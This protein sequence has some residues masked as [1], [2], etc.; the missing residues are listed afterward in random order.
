M[1][2]STLQK[3]AATTVVWGMFLAVAFMVSKAMFFPP[4]VDHG[5]HIESQS[6]TTDGI[7][8]DWDREQLLRGYQVATE[9]CMSCHSFKYISHRNLKDIG[10]TED[11]AKAMAAALDLGLND[12]MLSIMSPEDAKESYGKEVP[13]LSVMTKARNNG[14]NYVHALLTH[15]VDS[16]TFMTE[17]GKQIIAGDGQY[18]NKV[19]PGYLIAMPSPLSEDLVEYEDGTAATV[20][21]MS[22]DVTAFLTWTGD[23]LFV[24]KKRLGIMV[25]LYLLLFTTLCYKAY[26]AIWAKVK[27]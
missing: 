24:D 13:D 7:R 9:V 1:T 26:K 4:H 10:I 27:K 23:P 8:G 3:C 25:F 17:D 22:K 11:K 2:K 20:E 15:Y 21:Q 12:P 14:A 16:E 5:A 19:F 6:W 18:L